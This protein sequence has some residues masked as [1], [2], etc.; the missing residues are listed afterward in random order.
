[1]MNTEEIL[2]DQN[3]WWQDPASPRRGQQFPRRRELFSAVLERLMRFDDRRASVVTGPR[4]VG[5]TVMLQQIADELLKQGWPPGNITYFDFS[6]DRITAPGITA[7]EVVDVVPREHKNGKPRIFLLDEIGSSEKWASWLKQAVD[8]MDHRIVV[9]DSATSLVRKGGRE[10]G[11]GRWDE[12]VLEGLSFHEYLHLQSM[13]GESLDNALARLPSPLERYLSFGGFPEHLQ[14][15]S[16]SDVRRRIRSDVADKAILRDIQKLGVRQP[17][18]VK[19]LFIYLVADSGSIFD[20][21]TR[22][23][24]LD[25]DHRSV[26]DWLGLLED[27]LLVSRLEPL[28]R[29]KTAKL[30]GRSLPRIYAADHGLIVAFSSEADPMADSEVRG[31]VYEAAVYRH[32]RELSRRQEGQLGYFRSDD[33][34]KEIDFV[35]RT[36]KE[37]IAIEVTSSASPGKKPAKLKNMP[38]HL[39]LTS[40]VLV[41]GGLKEKRTGGIH[42]IP[43]HRFLLNPESIL[44]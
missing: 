9:T 23:G 21:R 22:K 6:D 5:K 24:D 16:L 26:S 32:L 1:M 31:K 35:L 44:S 8:T 41:Y 43:I 42:Q 40:K 38:G 3:P 13:E 28:A 30:R 39:K 7:R 18:K 34:K 10:S 15:N 14:S 20:L 11:M 25:A 2:F 19:D 37:T 17:M 4:Q 27:T 33:Q 36:S 12:H 29:R